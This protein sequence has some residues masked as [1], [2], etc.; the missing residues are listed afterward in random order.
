MG[1]RSVATKPKSVGCKAPEI[2]QRLAFIEDCGHE[3]LLPMIEFP[4]TGMSVRWLWPVPLGPAPR[5]VRKV[6]PLPGPGMPRR[7]CIFFQ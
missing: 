4:I 3:V 7:L 2:R 1:R 5:L 6:Q